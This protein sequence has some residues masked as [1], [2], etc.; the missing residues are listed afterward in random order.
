MKKTKLFVLAAMASL[1][2]VGCGGSAE[3]APGTLPAGGTEVDVSKEEGKTELK[4]RFNAAKEA[5]EKLDLTSGAIKSTTGLDLLVNA[6]AS[7]PLIGIKEAKLS[8][9]VKGLKV[10]T[11]AKVA[12]S[13]EGNVD[14]SVNAVVKDGTVSVSG[15][16]PAKEETEEKPMADFGSS[17][18]VKGAEA[19]AYLKGSYAYV[20]ISSKNNQKVAAGFDKF[21][22]NLM[23]SLDATSF[24]ALIPTL[25]EGLLPFYTKDGGFAFA[26]EFE[27]LDKQLAFDLGTAVAWP[28]ITTPETEES[29]LIPID[30]DSLIDVVTSETFLKDLNFKFETYKDGGFGAAIDVNKDNLVN[31]VASF[32]GVEATKIKETID[33]YLLDLSLK[34]SAHFNKSFLLDNVGFAITLKGKLDSLEAIAPDYASLISSFEATAD[35]SATES[36]SITYGGTKVSFPDFKD[37]VLVELPEIP[38]TPTPTEVEE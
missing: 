20:D 3:V 7:A 33:P 22:N 26:D 23:T 24:G 27:S 29:S 2:L 9:N 1:T 16:L 14:A 36:L 10:D 25:L 5:Y 30:I 35:L 12:K 11:T 13:A 32:A 15:S 28:E 31:L 19:N 8:A 17:F 21:G 4:N 6:K 34:A 18:S 37:Y 38:Q